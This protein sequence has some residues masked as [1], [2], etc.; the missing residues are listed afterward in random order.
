MIPE[1]WPA[2]SLCYIVVS[3]AAVH[4]TDKGFK[5]CS[6]QELPMSVP[7]CCWME[8][9][10]HAALATCSFNALEPR[11]PSQADTGSIPEASIPSSRHL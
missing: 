5:P 2:L 6:N 10:C 3:T 9:S 8:P 4:L 1:L 11:G 7:P